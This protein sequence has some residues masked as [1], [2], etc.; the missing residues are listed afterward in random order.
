M[1]YNFRNQYCSF[2]HSFIMGRNTLVKLKFFDNGN[3][4]IRNLNLDCSKCKCKEFRI[5]K[6]AC[7][8]VVCYITPGVICE[9]C[10]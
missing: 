3:N 10:T 8:I 4:Q 2:L 6:D 1:H 9:N 7:S 5:P